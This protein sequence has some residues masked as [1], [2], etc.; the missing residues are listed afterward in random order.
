MARTNPKP[1][2]RGRPPLPPAERKQVKRGVAMTAA[3]WERI[4]ELARELG[5]SPSEYMRLRALG[6][7]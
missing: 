4:G 3:D 5:L 2:K 7:L 6:A 1:P